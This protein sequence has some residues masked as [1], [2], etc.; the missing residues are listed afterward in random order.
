MQPLQ[1]LDRRELHEI[2]RI[3]SSL[4]PARNAQPSPFAQLRKMVREE[5][6]ERASIALLRA[7]EARSLR[8]FHIVVVCTE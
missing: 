8:R 1:Q 5:R 2:V 3:G 6:L 7:H 4:D